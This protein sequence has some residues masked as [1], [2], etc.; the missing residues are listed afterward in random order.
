[1]L[2][3]AGEIYQSRGNL[4]GNLTIAGTLHWLDGSHNG[5]GTTTVT[6][7]GKIVLD[8][9]C[10][11]G[12]LDDAR[13]VVNNGLITLSNGAQLFDGGFD[14]TAATIENA[15]TIRFADAVGDAC[16][17]GIFGSG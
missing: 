15:G 14:D 5:P 3:T 9:S 11:G 10:G 12:G 17:T 4:T 6:P 2:T 7:A 16:N 13:R 1:T 8:E